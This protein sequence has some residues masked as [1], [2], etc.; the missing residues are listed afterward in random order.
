MPTAPGLPQRIGFTAEPMTCGMLW[1][2]WIEWRDNITPPMLLRKDW[3]K[4]LNLKQ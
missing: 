1:R 4:E 3:E 2:C